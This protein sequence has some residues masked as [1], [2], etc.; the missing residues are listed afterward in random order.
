MDVDFDMKITLQHFGRLRTAELELKPLTLFC[1]PNNTGKTYAMYGVYGLV[2]RIASPRLE[3]LD[4][5]LAELNARGALEIDMEPLLERHRFEILDRA[6]SSFQRA[7]PRFFSAEPDLFSETKVGISVPDS[8]TALFR[9][10]SKEF[11]QKSPGGKTVIQVTK[12]AGS[13]TM[14]VTLSEKPA[15]DLLRTILSDVMVEAA[16]GDWT[17]RVLLL[18]AERAGLNL[19]YRELN[20]R[21]AALLHHASQ[22][23]INPAELLRD[24]FVSRYP[25]PI[26]DYI[27]L[28][29]G[30]TQL[31]RDAGTWQDLA[32]RLQRDVLSIK[33]YHIDRQGN[34]S[35]TPRRSLLKISLHL[36]SSVIKS[37]FG[38]WFFLEHLA[39]KDDVLMIDEPELN[40]HPENQRRLARLLARLVNLGAK[41]VLSTH[42]DYIMRE[43][44]N[45]LMIGSGKGQR[46][47]R[48]LELRYDEGEA[49]GAEQVGAYSFNEKGV[50]PIPMDPE[51][52]LLVK[53]FDDVI[54]GM[55]KANQELFE[56]GFDHRQ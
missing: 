36:G 40:L 44:N 19:F 3:F 42:S 25:Q 4:P 20:S 8:N 52:G 32:S 13:M 2:K 27:D 15:A 56:A 22:A 18:P 9:G 16:Y 28:L 49:L 24:I 48:A 55:N 5:L 38:L 43:F 6:A 33:G 23:E 34:V 10:R 21:R 50:E 7:L 46:R 29:N 47:Q 41:V 14:S 31:K 12:P 51:E 37:L 11:H 1:G 17:G 39:A 30:M 54:E 45:L 35:F 53:T 26:A